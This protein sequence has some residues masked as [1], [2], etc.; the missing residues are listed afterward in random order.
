VGPG[1]GVDSTAANVRV[2]AGDV[3]ERVGD[4][5]VAEELPGAGPV[6]PPTMASDSGTSQRMACVGNQSGPGGLRTCREIDERCCI[7]ES[8][9]DCT[10]RPAATLGKVSRQPRVWG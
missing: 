4:E 3:G 7:G 10:R 9:R 5:G 6:H 8:R 2:P 1:R